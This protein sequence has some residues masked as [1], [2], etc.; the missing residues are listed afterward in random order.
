M[1][2]SV[3]DADGNIRR[4]H[5]YR[6]CQRRLL[7]KSTSVPFED[8]SMMFTQLTNT[9]CQRQVVGVFLTNNKLYETDKNT[10]FHCLCESPVNNTAWFGLLY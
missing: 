10:M 4:I 8:K 7:Q 5:G 9:S 6:C 2:L 3:Q 1:N